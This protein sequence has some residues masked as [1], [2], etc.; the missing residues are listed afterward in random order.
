MT[1]LQQL[2]EKVPPDAHSLDQILGAEGTSLTAFLNPIS[3]LL[4]KEHRAVFDRCTSVYID[5]IS[6]V[7]LLRWLRVL[8]TE[9]ASFDMTSL[10]P[11]V[12]EWC[13]RHH[14]GIYFIGSRSHEV[15]RFVTTIRTAYPDLNVRG[16]RDG[17]FEA[18]EQATVA[19]K[20]S[21]LRPDVVVVGM[22]TPRQERFMLQLAETDPSWNVKVFTCGGFFHQTQERLHYY[23]AWVNRLNLR[24]AYRLVRERLYRRFLTIPWALGM[25]LRDSVA[26]HSAQHRPSH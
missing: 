22:G 11:R 3:Y 23:P 20:I 1:F 9:R 5:G 4:L 13:I 19:M 25:V 12:F 10:A 21:E 15:D 24:W 6:L 8:R 18:G 16:Y 14:K 26:Y 2:A 7:K 17:Y